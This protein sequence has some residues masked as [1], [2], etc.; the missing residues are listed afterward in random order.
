MLMILYKWLSYLVLR[1]W[2]IY[3]IVPG[4]PEVELTSLRLRPLAFFLPYRRGQGI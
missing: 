4:T 2:E 3:Y 1:V